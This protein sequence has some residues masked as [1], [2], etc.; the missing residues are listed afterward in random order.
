M[1]EDCVLL[2]ES[3]KYGGRNQLCTSSSGEEEGCRSRD[4]GNRHRRRDAMILRENS[5]GHF[6]VQGTVRISG[7]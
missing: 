3:Q 7:K 6:G 2:R 4:P 5:K 1:L